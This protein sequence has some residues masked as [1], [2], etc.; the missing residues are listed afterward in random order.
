MATRKKTTTKKSAKTTVKRTAP[1]KQAA[2]S[3]FWKVKLTT[4]TLYWLLIG[5]AV[6]A[7][8]LISYD[9]NQR[10]NSVYDEVEATSE[11]AY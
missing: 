1:R 5:V 4:N 8:A 9:T 11:Q 7:T 10:I 2:S 6:I 3:H